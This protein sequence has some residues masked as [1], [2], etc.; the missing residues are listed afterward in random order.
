[1]YGEIV[2]VRHIPLV[3]LSAR[4]RRTLLA[5]RLRLRLGVPYGRPSRLAYCGC[6]A[7]RRSVWQ[8]E[9][10]RTCLPYI[11][12]GLATVTVASSQVPHPALCGDEAESMPC[13]GLGVRG[14][15]GGMSWMPRLLS[16]FTSFFVLIIM[17]RLLA[18]ALFHLQCAVRASCS[19][20]HLWSSCRARA[21]DRLRA[22]M[23]G[24]GG[25]LVSRRLGALH[26]AMNVVFL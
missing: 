21:H 9:E 4:P 17:K 2:C 18:L 26:A 14:W 12:P 6:G 20:L 7:Q 13:M 15:E 19:A 25:S 8:P 22:L 1:M 24:G 23:C 16:C 3:A 10:T 5:L 11:L